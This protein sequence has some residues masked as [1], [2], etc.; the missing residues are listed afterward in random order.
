METGHFAGVSKAMNVRTSVSLIRYQHYSEAAELDHETGNL[1]VIKRHRNPS[2]GRPYWL[3]DVPMHGWFDEVGGLQVVVYRV[4]D[5]PETLWLRLGHR[6]VAFSETVRSEFSPQFVDEEP[7]PESADVLRTFRL[8][9][10]DQLVAEHQYRLHDLSKRLERAIDPFPS[11]PEEEEDYDLL[12]FVH[13]ITIGERWRRVLQ[14]Q[15][16]G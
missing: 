13:R 7:H 9:E 16:Q 6:R 14:L 4:P 3:P 1:T 8:F 12:Y 10:G 15:S 5:S 2:G 11:W